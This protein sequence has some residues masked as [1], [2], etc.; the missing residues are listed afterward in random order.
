MYKYAFLLYLNDVKIDYLR[1]YEMSFYTSDKI[2]HLTNRI[3]YDSLGIA[4]I[5]DDVNH[6]KAEKILEEINEALMAIHEEKNGKL[7]EMVMAKLISKPMFKSFQ[8]I[9]EIATH[10]L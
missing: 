8:T 3:K 2:K 1:K 7:E 9:S 10:T 4:Y 6:D 5:T